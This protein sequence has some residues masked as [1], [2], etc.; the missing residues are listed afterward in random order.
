MA[1]D[2]DLCAENY[3]KLEGK[4]RRKL[5]TAQNDMKHFLAEQSEPDVFVQDALMLHAL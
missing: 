1:D 5:H 3:E 2:Y 4:Y